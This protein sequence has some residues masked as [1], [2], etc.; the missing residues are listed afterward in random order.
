M[1]AVRRS[2]A[3][4]AAAVCGIGT[5]ALLA[6]LAGIGGTPRGT[7][8]PLGPLLL[9]GAPLALAA[10]TGVAKSSTP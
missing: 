7:A 9:A 1:G 8:D 5:G 6:L 10:L 2:E 3:I 4:M